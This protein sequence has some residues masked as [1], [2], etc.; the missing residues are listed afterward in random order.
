M[1]KT[2]LLCYRNSQA[3]RPKSCLWGGS[4]GVINFHWNFL[5]NAELVP[6]GH[7]RNISGHLFTW[8]ICWSLQRRHGLLFTDCIVWDDKDKV[9]LP[10]LRVFEYRV[11]KAS[12]V[13]IITA[14]SRH[15]LSIDIFFSLL[16]RNMTLNCKMQLSEGSWDKIL[17]FKSRTQCFSKEKICFLTVCLSSRYTEVP[18]IVFATSLQRLPR[19][20]NNPFGTT[21]Y[22]IDQWTVV[23]C[24][25][26]PQ[27]LSTVRHPTSSDGKLLV[28]LENNRG[29]GGKTTPGNGHA[30]SLLSP[31]R[32][33][34]TG[35]NGGNRLQNHLWC[36]KDSRG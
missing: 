4:K 21:P 24:Q 17:H 6:V 14:F 27:A 1:R 18:E 13:S 15:K 2:E 12:T 30:W 36:P 10:P 29:R 23:A 7:F 20:V 22:T 31:R 9:T 16:S 19:K 33:R 11:F 3:R 28:F 8:L 32:Q 34:R 26:M 5:C 25:T 35:K